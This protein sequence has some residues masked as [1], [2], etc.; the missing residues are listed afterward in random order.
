MVTD[1]CPSDGDTDGAGNGALGASGSG[2][3]RAKHLPAGP[4]IKNGV[5]IEVRFGGR[6]CGG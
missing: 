3:V 1:S 4:L 2:G 5:F 6:L